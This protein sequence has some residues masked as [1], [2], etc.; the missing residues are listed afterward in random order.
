MHLQEKEKILSKS[1][2]VENCLNKRYLKHIPFILH[3]YAFYVHSHTY[4]RTCAH[5][6][7]HINSENVKK[8][9]Y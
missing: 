2:I 5:A 3:I 7:A 6:Y 8:L 9:S 4:T 1:E